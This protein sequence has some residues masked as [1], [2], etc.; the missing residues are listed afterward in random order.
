MKSKVRKIRLC[1]LS[2]LKVVPISRTKLKRSVLILKKQCKL[3]H[4]Q[5]EYRFEIK[6]EEVWKDLK[7]LDK[8]IVETRE[9]IHTTKRQL[10]QYLY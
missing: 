6:R 7:S 1:I 3:A 4:I 5:L 2:C 10:R 9:I 8:Q